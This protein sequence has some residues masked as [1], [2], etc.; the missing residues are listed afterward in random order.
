MCNPALMTAVSIGGSVLGFVQQMRSAK[1]QEEVAYANYDLRMK[2]AKLRDEQ[3][4]H[5][6][7]QGQEE[8]KLLK[9]KMLALKGNQQA[10]FGARNINITS[11]TPSDILAD[12]E[13]I[14]WEDVE[15]IRSNT[16][17][18]QEYYTKL[19]EL[20]R[21]GADIGL[22]SDLNAASQTR[23]NAAGELIGASGQVASKWYRYKKTGVYS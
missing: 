21:Q 22:G 13:Q 19:G 6:L 4:A 20:E 10:T 5:T 16:K 15:N 7:A 11:G 1:A 2:N 9:R 23:V 18:K 8:E 12:T 14:M 3:A 17:H